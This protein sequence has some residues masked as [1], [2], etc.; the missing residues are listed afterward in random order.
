PPAPPPAPRPNW[1][2]PYVSYGYTAP[3]Q[4]NAT[5]PTALVLR[6]LF[7][8]DCGQ[9]VHVASDTGS[10]SLTLQPGPACNDTI[11]TWTQSFPLGML[12][13]GYHVIHVTEHFISPDSNEVFQGDFGFQVW[14][15][16]TTPPPA[17]P[18][19]IEYPSYLIRCL[20]G[21]FTEAPATTHAPTTL[22]LFGW[23]PYRCGYTSDP[24]VGGRQVSLTLNPSTVCSPID[25][26]V[27]W[28]QTFDL[29]TLPAGPQTFDIALGVVDDPRT[30]PGTV[31]RHAAIT[32]DV[33]DRDVSASVPNPFVT[34]TSFVI[35]TQK[36]D[37]VEVGIYDLNGRRVASLFK[38][39]LEAGARAFRWDGRR[40]DGSRAAIGIYFSRVAFSNRVV[41]RKLV[42]LPK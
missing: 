24:S 17:P 39:R 23:F 6:G 14:A 1:V 36:P 33:D 35:N 28:H 4:P 10:V 18:G 37:D 30:G 3:S 5:E 12:A 42:M 20:S 16:S 26:V 40:D 21:W 15:D 34:A 25:S 8:Y 41:T 38:R 27:T 22:V 11:R 7:P 19:P 13:Q 32:I 9:V 31:I 2:V 29:G